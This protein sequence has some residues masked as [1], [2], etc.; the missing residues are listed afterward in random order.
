MK[1]IAVTEHR[2]DV[3]ATWKAVAK[4]GMVELTHRNLGSMVLMTVEHHEAL[5]T[6]AKLGEVEC[7]DG[8]IEW[9]GGDNPVPGNEVELVFRD[10]QEMV[11]SSNFM[12]WSS[13]GRCGDIIRYRVIKGATS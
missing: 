6:Q 3:A 10:D 11:Y 9:S 1:T 12:D 8:W 7:D 5:L 13:D 2:D 4:H